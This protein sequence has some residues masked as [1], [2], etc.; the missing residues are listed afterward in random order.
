MT[1]LSMSSMYVSHMRLH[2]TVP[3]HMRAN[4]YSNDMFFYSIDKDIFAV[5]MY[6]I[7][8]YSIAHA[9]CFYIE[10]NGSSSGQDYGKVFIGS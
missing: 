1:P 4:L 9:I 2:T 10:I 3:H 8:I 6:S 5:I 7:L